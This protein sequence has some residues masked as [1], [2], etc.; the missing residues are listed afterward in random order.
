MNKQQGKISYDRGSRVLSLAVGKGKSVDSDIRGN[1]VIDVDKKGN[2][3]RVDI[4]SFSFDAFR[5]GK[6]KLEHFLGSKA[7]VVQLR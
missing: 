3:V 4:H 6:G 5:A 1:V 7:R 2:P